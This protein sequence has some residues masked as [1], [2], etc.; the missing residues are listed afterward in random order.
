MFYLNVIMYKQVFN[1]K[2]II[3][4]YIYTKLSDNYKLYVYYYGLNKI[5]EKDKKITKIRNYVFSKYK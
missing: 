5:K 3:Y 4:L 2:L 1:L